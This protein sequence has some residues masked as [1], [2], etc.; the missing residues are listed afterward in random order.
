MNWVPREILLMAAE[1]QKKHLVDTPLHH[2]EALVATLNSVWLK[3][4]A[5]QVSVAKGKYSKKVAAKKREM[6]SRA[7]MQ[8]VDL[9]KQCERLQKQLK[10]ANARADAA[11]R[12]PELNPAL[13]GK[14]SHMRHETKS[15]EDAR[16]ERCGLDSKTQL[17]T[18]RELAE[19]V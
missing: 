9:Q 11:Q 6:N 4:T 14:T 16:A 1:Y 7:P 15:R 12:E 19:Q 18:Q 3:L 10:V 2:I 8:Y 13:P 17:H 5:M